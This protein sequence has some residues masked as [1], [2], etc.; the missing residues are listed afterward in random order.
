MKINQ[1][2]LLQKTE[3]Q[4]KKN[5][6]KELQDKKNNHMIRIKIKLMKFLN[7]KNIRKVKNLQNSKKKDMSSQEVHQL[8]NHN[9]VEVKE[10]LEVVEEEV[11]VEVAHVAMAIIAMSTK[12]RVTLRI[13]TRVQRTRRKR[14]R[15]PNPMEKVVMLAQHSRND[16]LVMYDK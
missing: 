1:K 8:K 10:N 16:L 6:E 7:R 9:L 3:L 2:I 15:V 11:A 4:E 12:C 13:A 5:I 14:N